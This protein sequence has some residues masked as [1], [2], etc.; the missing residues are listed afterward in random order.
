MAEKF[1]SERNVKFMLYE[2]FDVES[3]TEREYFQD[4]GREIFDMVL[5]TGSKMSR[6]LSGNPRLWRSSSPT[7]SHRK[8]QHRPLKPTRSMLERPRSRQ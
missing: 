1:V 2:M 3:L 8:N 4:H 7:R 6:E 5:E